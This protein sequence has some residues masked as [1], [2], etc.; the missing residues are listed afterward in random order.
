MSLLTG[1]VGLCTFH[2][3]IGTCKQFNSLQLP[4]SSRPSVQA[5]RTQTASGHSHNVEWHDMTDRLLK[6]Q[7]DD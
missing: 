4:V 7:C 1:I 3:G 5:P 6:H 2:S